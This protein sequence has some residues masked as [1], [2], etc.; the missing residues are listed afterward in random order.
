MNYY[1]PTYN[2]YLNRANGS[3]TYLLPSDFTPHLHNWVE[4]SLN[5]GNT[6]TAF[7]LQ[8][9][10]PQSVKIIKFPSLKTQTIDVTQVFSINDISPPQCW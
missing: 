5:N 10:G 7:V 9:T 1:Y 3:S 2:P 8:V 4:L 6:M